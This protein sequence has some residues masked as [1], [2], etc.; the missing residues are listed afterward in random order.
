M[1]SV[2]ELSI[3]EAKMIEYAYKVADALGIRYGAVHG[4]YMIDDNGPVLIE[5]NCRPMG[6]DM[7]VDFLDRISGQHETDSVL[8]AYL[9]PDLFKEQLKREYQLFAHASIKFFIV[10]K[11]IVA[12]SAPMKNI[13]L[14]LESHLRTKLEDISSGYSLNVGKTEDL[15]SSPGTMYLVHEDLSVVQ[16]DIEFIRNIERNAFSMV[17]SSEM[18]DVDLKDDESYINDVRPLVEG[19][20]KYGI[21]LFVTDQFIDD[22]DIL[23]VNPLDIDNVIGTFDF[24]V[25]NL[26]KSIV[27]NSS[28]DVIESIWAS[29]SKVKKNGFIFIPENTYELLDGGRN[30][31]EVLIKAAG[32]KIVLPPYGVYDTIMAS[33]K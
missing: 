25:I 11:D 1:D 22:V 7:T 26:N 18:N 24:I 30:S 3:G 9:K 27:N 23:Q 29:F 2:N 4:E 33:K 21:G 13:S 17:L 19:C 5:V 32:L 15:H 6:G 16:K 20:Q 31:M 12:K 10:S 8:Y 14:K 28:K